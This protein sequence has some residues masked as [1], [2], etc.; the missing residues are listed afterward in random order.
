MQNPS[1]PRWQQRPSNPHKQ[2]YKFPQWNDLP[3]P[4]P[5]L[6]K[7]KHPS[8]L[9]SQAVGRFRK[10]EDLRL[11]AAH[12][13]AQAKEETLRGEQLEQRA[14]RWHQD[15]ARQRFRVQE[16]AWVAAEERRAEERKALAQQAAARA[17]VTRVEEA[18]KRAA[19]AHRAQVEAAVA[20]AVVAVE[21]EIHREAH[22]P[23]Q[24]C[25]VRFQV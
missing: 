4:L 19:E 20:A 10:A 16:A 11:Q 7:E 13:L 1:Q 18:R 2:T 24:E 8:I 6:P 23:L 12:L 5:N 21:A 22:H 15:R 14:R 25:R 9:L 3:R 17:E